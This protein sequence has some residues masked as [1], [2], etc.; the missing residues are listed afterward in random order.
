MSVRAWVLGLFAL[1]CLLNTSAQEAEKAVIELGPAV[2]RSLTEGQT[3]VGP[4]VAV[5]VTPIEN[6]L[7]LEAGITALFQSHATEWSVDFLFEKPWIFSDRF[8]FMIGIG[9][10]W[11]HTD[12]YGIKTNSIAIEVAPDFMFWHSVRHRFGWYLEPM[13]EYEF[14]SPREQSLGINGGLLIGIR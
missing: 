14:G 7:E 2:S 10:E 11:V 1:L 5:E 12:T 8:E 4:A 3:G 13:Y 9:P 6:R